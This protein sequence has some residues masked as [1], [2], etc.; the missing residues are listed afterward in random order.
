MY[1][2]LGIGARIDAI[3]HKIRHPKHQILWRNNVE[4]GICRGDI[5]CDTCGIVYWCRGWK[6]D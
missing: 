6:G 4:E 1:F 5:L 3:K 2:L